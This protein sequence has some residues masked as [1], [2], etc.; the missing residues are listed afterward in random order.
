MKQIVFL[1]FLLVFTPL[2]LGQK[3]VE[4]TSCTLFQ[5]KHKKETIN[6]IVADTN[7]TTQKPIFLFCQGSLPVPLFFDCGINKKG[8][9]QIQPTSLN[10][11]D[12]KKL[13]QYYHVVVISMPYTPISVDIRMLNKQYCYITDTSRQH[14]YDTS[15]LRADVAENYIKRANKVIQFVLN[16]AWAKGK[17]VVLAGHSQ[18]ARIAVGIAYSNKKVSKVGLFGYN[19]LNRITQIILQARKNAEKGK[20]TWEKADTI[21][22][23]QYE[24]MR[25]IQIEDSVKNHPYMAAWKSF[26]SGSLDRLVQLKQAV[27]IAYGSNDIIAD[28]CDNIPLYFIQNGKENYTIK[29]YGGLNHNFFPMGNDGKPNHKLGKWKSVMNAFVAWSLE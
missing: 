17:K 11:F 13:N 8:E 28:F 3:K 5:L 20:I 9:K 29:R 6:F 26:S 25:L 7:L 18:G 12:L 21:C 10:N 15:Y 1:I 2:A 4:G 27:Y 14:S 24:F 19:P 16:Q 22:Q 23:N